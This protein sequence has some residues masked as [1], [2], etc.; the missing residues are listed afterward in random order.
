VLL[1]VSDRPIGGQLARLDE[2]WRATEQGWSA[3]FPP[4]DRL[5]AVR[6][7][8]HAVQVQPRG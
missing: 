4:C 5:T 6:D 1:D 2:V 8:G 7:A 3:F